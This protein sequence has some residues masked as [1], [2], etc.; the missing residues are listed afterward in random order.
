MDRVAEPELMLHPDQARAYAAADFEE[1]HGRFID[2][3]EERL[4]D[5]PAAGTGLDLG[6]GPGDITLRFARAF[7]SWSIDAV[8]G[9]AAMLE[10]GRR[11]TARERLETRVRFHEVVLPEE[12]PPF[13]P[14]DLVFSNALLHHLRE[15]QVLWSTARQWSGSDTPLFV[16]DLIRPA[17]R[18]RAR[19]LVDRHARDEPD[20]L[21]TDFYNSLLAGYRAPE[22]REQLDRASL[23]H[24]DVE[25][26]SDRHFI[27]W[28]PIRPRSRPAA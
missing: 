14:Y 21:R 23:S 27:V 9:S 18:E 17:S 4:F 11:A 8:D 1:P 28:G 6:C 15:P 10:L 7:P 5:L 12:S 26:V 3:L 20:I 25:V 2:L 19:E 16:M 24:L 22:I 13:R